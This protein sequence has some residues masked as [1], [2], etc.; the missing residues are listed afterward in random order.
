M[1]AARTEQGASRPRICL[2]GRNALLPQGTGVSTYAG[3]LADS[4]AL[5]GMGLEL[6]VDAAADRNEA[7][8]RLRRWLAAASPMTRTAALA[9]EGDGSGQ[10]RLRVANDVFRTAQV[11]FDIHRRLLRIG[12]REP[13]AAMHWTYPVPIQFRGVPNL[14]T[15]H[16]LIPLLRPE[17]TPIAGRRLDRILRRIAGSGAHLVTVSET[18]RR[19]IIAALGVPADQV[20][21][22][23]QAVHFPPETVAGQEEVARIL[24]RLGRLKPGGFFLHAGTVEPRKNLARLIQAYRASGIVTPLVIAGPDGWRA[25][26]ELLP[27]GD[28]L[29]EGVPALQDAPSVL[30]LPWLDRRL[31][32]SLIRGAKAVLLPSLAEGF[33]LPVA[34]AMA[35]GTPAMTSRGG[36]TEEIAGGAAMLVDPLDIADMAGALAALDRDAA[37]RGSL[38]GRGLHRAALF[39]V[40]VYAARLRAL[41]DRVLASQPRFGSLQGS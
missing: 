3:V 14:C 6:L 10:A 33:G 36:A 19:E 2:D 29:R 17:L 41:Y 34:E 38:A 21:N 40:E 16:D 26:D 12:G 7:R 24:H 11:H 32:V 9:A 31:L 18:S 13:P 27:A 30:R 35:L 5:T 4:M 23:F 25:A 22:T 1:H 8:P 15:V 39:S 28:W 37:L 20:T